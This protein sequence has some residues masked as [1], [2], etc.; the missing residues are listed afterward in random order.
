M[1]DQQ[2]YDFFNALSENNL[3]H[4]EQLCNLNS[5]LINSKNQAGQSPLIKS[6]LL[7]QDFNSLKF[8]IELGAEPDCFEVNGFSPLMLACEKNDLKTVSFLLQI[9]A[10]VNNAN[11]LG[12]SALF[13][14]V[15]N[16]NTVLTQM[17]LAHNADFN[18]QNYLKQQ[19]LHLACFEEDIES[20]KILLKA[21]SSINVQDFQG[22]T[23]LFIAENSKSK[24]LKKLFFEYEKNISLS[25][26]AHLICKS[27]LTGNLDLF[28]DLM[29]KNNLSEMD[30]I[31]IFFATIKHNQKEML[32]YLN[33]YDPSLILKTNKLGEPPLEKAYFNTKDPDLLKLLID[34]GANINQQNKDHLSLL[35]LACVSA[36]IRLAKFLLNN[37]ADPN[38]SDKQGKTPLFYAISS[39]SIK[40][41][42]LL[43]KQGSQINMLDRNQNSLLQTCFLDENDDMFELLSL[44]QSETYFIRNKR[45]MNMNYPETDSKNENA[46]DTQNNLNEK[47][48]DTKIDKNDINQFMHHCKNGDLKLL[49]EMLL[50]EPKLVLLYDEQGNLAQHIAAF[51][52]KK[53]VLEYLFSK[54][55]KPNLKNREGKTALHLVLCSKYL[56]DKDFG[57]KTTLINLLL[58]WGSNTQI[59]DNLNKSP[60]DYVDKK[61]NED[62]YYLLLRNYGKSSN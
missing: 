21:G 46:K 52:A 61:E 1:I 2:L 11:I 34:L 33:E 29:Q 12:E 6:Y 56:E 4:I 8:L 15:R 42:E 57:E 54:G 14:T 48:S 16:K 39:N 44:Y 28:K 25:K 62:L 41:C 5:Q 20:S 58:D 24:G 9:G 55:A 49:Q 59:K 18:Q 7:H 51:F 36:D 35:H 40:I 30:K 19:V 22:K 37:H 32:F 47:N 17:L 45:R 38:L 13:F 23:P 60:L 3:K 10:K 27:V 26:T 50:K 53:E 31:D 43:L